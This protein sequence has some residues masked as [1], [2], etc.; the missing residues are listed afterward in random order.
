MSKTKLAS[1]FLV[2]LL[3]V[4]VFSVSQTQAAFIVEAHVSGLANGNFSFGGDTTTATAS[5]A[6]NAVGLTATNSLFGGD[7]VA[8]GDTYVFSYTPGADVDNFAPAGGSI[9]GSTTGF[10]TEIASGLVGG[11]SGLYNVY[12]TTPQS[13]NVNPAGSSF[14][15]TNAGAPVVV[16]PVVQNNGGTGPDLDPGPAFVGG[17]NDA[18]F[19]LGTVQLSAGTTY[20]VAQAANV[21]TFVSQR[22]H[23]I[24]WEAIPEPAS[25]ILAALAGLG[26]ICSARRRKA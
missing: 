10:G 6:S 20:T 14:T 13:T 16:N 12:F 3:A 21:N 2:V 18:W 26:V 24:M 4:A 7:G 1:L 11:G 15:I 22:S 9:L 19:L 25:M 5:L 23:A 8:F 17:A